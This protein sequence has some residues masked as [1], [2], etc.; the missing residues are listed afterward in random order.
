[1]RCAEKKAAN[2]AQERT[3]QRI[4]LA[5]KNARLQAGCAN[6][7]SY[8]ALTAKES[9]LLQASSVPTALLLLLLLLLYVRTTKGAI[10]K[11]RHLR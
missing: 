9:T 7:K 8:A 6:T 2:Y 3:T 4:T 10:L 5:A 11:Q 1:M